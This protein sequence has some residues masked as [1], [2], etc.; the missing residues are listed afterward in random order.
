M[1]WMSYLPVIIPAAV[2][3]ALI[4][5]SVILKLQKDEIA[6]I[7]KEVTEFLLVVHEG[8]AD[9]TVTPEELQKMV[10][11]MEDVLEKAAELLK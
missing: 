6:G 4:A 3:V 9:G 11:E 7:G 8:V 5:L 10:D 1:D 2:S